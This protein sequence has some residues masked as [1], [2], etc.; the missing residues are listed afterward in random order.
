MRMRVVGFTVVA[1]LAGR[2]AAPAEAAAQYRSYHRLTDAVL[3]G[4]TLGANS[5]GVDGFGGGPEATALV[6]IPIGDVVQLRAEGGAAV[7]R[8]HGEPF[9]GIEGSGMRR[10]RLT[11]SFIRGDAPSAS[12]R[13]RGYGGGGPGLYFHRFP[14]RPNGGSWGIHGLAGL[15]VLLPTVRSR[16][17]VGAEVQLHLYGQPHAVADVTTRPMLAAHASVLLKYRLP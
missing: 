10:Y 16:W 2:L 5:S 12:R 7:W 13:V 11:A 8:Y 3:V 15:D 14:K 1:L 9:Y 6:E 17:I 4:A